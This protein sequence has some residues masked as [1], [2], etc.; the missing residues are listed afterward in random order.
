[1]RSQNVHLLSELLR[2]V[3]PTKLINNR[4]ES[5]QATIDALKS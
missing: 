4:L 2:I 5:Q 3:H 1:M